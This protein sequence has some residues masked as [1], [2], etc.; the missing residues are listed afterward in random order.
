[1]VAAHLPVE[2]ADREAVGPQQADQD[3][4]HD[5]AS[6]RW[7]TT[8]ELGLEIPVRRTCCGRERPDH[9]HAAGRQR[10]DPVP[11]QVAQPALHTVPGHG[12]DPPIWPRRSRS[13]PAHCRQI[14]LSLCRH[15]GPPGARPGMDRRQRRPRR[16]ASG[17]RR[18]SSGGCWRKA[19]P[20]PRPQ[21]A[22]LLRPLRRR[23]DRIA[24]PAR[25]RIRRRKPCTL[26]RRRLFGWYVRLL[27]SSPRAL[28]T[29]DWDVSATG[30]H[31]TERRQY[32]EEPAGTACPRSGP[33]AA[34]GGDVT[35]L[36]VDMRHRSNRSRPA[37]GTW[38][39]RAGSI[40]PGRDADEGLKTT[41]LHARCAD[42]ARD[43]PGNRAKPVDN[44]LIPARA[45]CC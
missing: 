42:V 16:T 14:Y 45:D 34:P 20:W 19:H 38:R 30:S 44:R 32:S 3:A 27:T 9:E 12:R 35:G 4:L 21:T 33:V 36:I 43:T 10:V 1:M 39:A 40:P 15:S 31:D 29:S 11:H 28:G 25:V 7:Q 18:R 24:R 22:R 17:S 26:C 37:N 13:G 2:R 5:G 23:E 41:M 6:S 8:I